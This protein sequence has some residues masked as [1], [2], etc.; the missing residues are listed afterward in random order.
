MKKALPI[1][2]AVIALA[3]GGYA[4]YRYLDQG[5]STAEGVVDV[6]EETPEAYAPKGDS[7]PDEADAGPLPMSEAEVVETAPTDLENS[8]GYLQERLSGRNAFLTSV[9]RDQKHLIRKMTTAIDLAWQGKN[10]GS[11]LFFLR[12]TG[13][14][15]VDKRDNRYFLSPR[16]YERYETMT[17]ALESLDADT[18]TT[19]Y[20]ELRPLFKGA[21]DELGNADDRWEAKA[22]ALMDDV[23]E[24]QLPAGEIELLETG[25]LFI[26]ADPKLEDL[27]PAHKALIRM[28]PENAL[29]IQ[30]KLRELRQRL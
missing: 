10:P 26:F 21:Y 23:I 28:G 7:P 9:L 25:G 29:R 22:A 17:R 27:S 14:L 16:N 11:Q 12:P 2:I 24:L 6:V 4:V 19:M 1:V 18:L 20:R 5:P 15:L 3:A 30:N 13:E 8:D